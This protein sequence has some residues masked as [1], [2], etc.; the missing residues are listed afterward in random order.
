M[1]LHNSNSHFTKL[2]SFLVLVMMVAC[3]GKYDS[4]T[5]F[6]D[7]FAE[8]SKGGKFGFISVDGKE[9]IP[10]KYEDVSSFV[11]EIAKV[12]M[13]NK[14]GFVN[15]EGKE[16]IAPKYDKVYGFSRGLAKVEI[17]GKFGFVS[18][19]GVEVVEPKYEACSYNIIGKYF[20]V[21]ENGQKTQIQNRDT[22]QL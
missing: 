12:K 6:I 4:Q 16:V 5:E 21:V 17:K 14:Y 10:P 8:V 2:F 3:G 9:V 18:E 15:K 11:G 1:N 7:G 19:K 20:E 22:A 13:N